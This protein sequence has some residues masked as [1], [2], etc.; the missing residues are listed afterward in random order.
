MPG[1]EQLP[2]AKMARRIK[3]AMRQH[4]ITQ[5]ELARQSGESAMQVSRILS[6]EYMPSAISLHKIA[7]V[8]KREVSDFMG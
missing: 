6:G 7:R 5:A 4:P 1:I 2:H 3:T 8:L